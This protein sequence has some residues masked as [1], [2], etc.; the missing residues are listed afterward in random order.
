MIITHIF[1]RSEDDLGMRGEQ[2][3][4]GLVSQLIDLVQRER[5]SG[6]SGCGEM[7]RSRSGSE[8]SPEGHVCHQSEE[9]HG[10]V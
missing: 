5:H 8:A 9:S 4:L 2:P 7:M 3:G 6:G 10:Y 1:K